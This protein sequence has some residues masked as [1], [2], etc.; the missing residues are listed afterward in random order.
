[1]DVTV[2][3]PRATPGVVAEEKEEVADDGKTVALAK[4]GVTDLARITGRTSLAREVGEVSLVRIACTAMQAFLLCHHRQGGTKASI[5]TRRLG[6]SRS[7][8]QSLPSW[9]ERR[10][11]PHSASSSSLLA[12]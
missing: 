1:M 5:K 3:A 4:G 12:R 11:Q 2:D 10:P 8:A 7:R 9:V 6:A